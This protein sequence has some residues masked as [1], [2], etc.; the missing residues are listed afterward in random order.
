MNAKTLF[1]N[2]QLTS[3]TSGEQFATV[4]PATGETLAQIDQASADDVQAAVDAAKQGF[5]VWSRMTAMERSRILLKAV[6]LLRER[7]DE[8]AKLEVLDTGKPI[9]EA[10]EVDVVTGADAIEY[11]A[12][13]VPSM[14]GEQQPLSDNQFFYTRREPLGVCAGIGAWNYPIQIAMWKSAPALAAGN[15]MVFKPSEETPLTALKLAEIFAEAGMPAGVFN[16]VQG[17]YRVGQMLTAHP[18]IAKVSFTGEVGT[19]K[20][21]MGDAAKTLKSVTMELGGKSPCIV[22]DDADLDNA[23]SAAMVANFYTQGEVCTHGT[24]VFVHDSIY[25]AFVEQLKARTE[26]LVIGDPTD[27]NTQVGAL[28][29]TEHLNKVMTAIETAKQSGATLLTGGYRVTENGLDK[30]NFV[31]PTIFTDCDDSMAHVRD[32]IFG[33]VM[34]VLRFSDEEEVVARAN[35][36]HYGLAAGV[37]TQNLSRA[38]RIIHQLEAGICWVNT[39][40]DSPAEMPVGGYK[41]SGV[42]RENG[43]ETLTHY[44]QTKSVLI[45]LGDFASPYA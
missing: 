24:R 2:G 20:T 26:K 19:G 18:E 34:S 25:D 36:T 38:H 6:A 31:A 12:N 33:P 16:V 37:F 8:L 3:A 23:V 22:F 1:I 13:L 21:V 44:T 5:A 27:M 10:V 30:G 15:A 43:V 28:I 35:N 4:N 29:S 40:G 11:F 7:N 42:G 41:H 9:Q 45:E 14:Q 32:E 17:D 39:W